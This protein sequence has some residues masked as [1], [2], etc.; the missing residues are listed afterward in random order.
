MAWLP[1]ITDGYQLFYGYQWFSMVT[2]DC[3]WSPVVVMVILLVW[4]TRDKII[5]ELHIKNH[6]DKRYIEKY[7]PKEVLSEDMNTMSCEQTLA[8]LSRF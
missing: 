2:R 1:E 5:D 7:S 4:Y 8:W 3:A 6:T